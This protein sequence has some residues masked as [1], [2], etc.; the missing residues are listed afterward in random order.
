[1]PIYSLGERRPELRGRCF[2][3]DTAALIGSVILEDEASVWFN[4]VVRGDSDLITIGRRTNVQDGSVLHADPDVPLTLGES[5]TVGHKVMLH[6]CTVGDNALIG[7][8]S[9]VLNHAVIGRNCLVGANTLIPERKTFPEGVLILGQ[10]GKVIRELKPEEMDGLR[11]AADLYVERIARYREH[12]RP[13]AT[14]A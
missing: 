14:R 3:A 9:V 7:I 5:V 11:R 10:P 2:V 8:N 4:T 6:G 1:M 12:L 13:F